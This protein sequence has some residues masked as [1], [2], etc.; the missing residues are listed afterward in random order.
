VKVE[1]IRWK[2]QGEVCCH[3]LSSKGGSP[4]LCRLRT[5][6]LAPVS[7]FDYV[8]AHM[9]FMG[10]RKLSSFNGC[11]VGWHPTTPAVMYIGLVNGPPMDSSECG[12]MWK[13][14]TRVR[15]ARVESLI[16]VTNCGCL[17]CLCEPHVSCCQVVTLQGVNWLESPWHSWIWVILACCCHS[18]V[19]LLS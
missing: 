6:H 13:T 11:W 19:I 10:S 8:L 1:N 9:E 15:W 16:A 18:V 12:M 2:G 7:K 14:C 3:I 4:H 17:W 5:D